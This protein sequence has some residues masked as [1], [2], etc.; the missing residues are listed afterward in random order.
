MTYHLNSKQRQYNYVN[1]NVII[2]VC[3]E[4]YGDGKFDGSNM[5]RKCWDSKDSESC[6]I[7]QKHLK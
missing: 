1:N 7:L 4:I 2:N 6:G 5:F 3:L